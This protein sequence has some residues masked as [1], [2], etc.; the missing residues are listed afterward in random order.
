MYYVQQLIKLYQYQEF[1][2][3]PGTISRSQAALS[4]YYVIILIFPLK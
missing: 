3:L 1:Y 2:N 4:T